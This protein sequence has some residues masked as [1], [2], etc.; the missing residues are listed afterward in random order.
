MVGV[1]SL[2]RHGLA[3]VDRGGTQMTQ[4]L[5]LLLTTMAQLMMGL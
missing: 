1:L 3:E 5:L 4:L 2:L